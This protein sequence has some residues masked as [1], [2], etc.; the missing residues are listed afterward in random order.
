MVE[1]P[2]DHFLR[3]LMV[4]P[5]SGRRVPELMSGDM[6]WL[7]EFICDT[8]DFE[9]LPE[10]EVERRGGNGQP[11]VGVGAAARQQHTGSREPLPST[12]L[13]RLDHGGQFVVDGHHRVAAHL[14]VAVAQIDRALRVADQTVH[15]KPGAVADAQAGADE[16][17]HQQPDPRVADPIEVGWAFQLVHDELGNCP[18]CR[19]LVAARLVAGIQLRLSRQRCPTVLANSMQ[20]PSH[21]ADLGTAGLRVRDLDRQSCQVGLQR[22]PVEHIRAGRARQ[23]RC[24]PRQPHQCNAV[25]SQLPQPDPARHSPPAPPLGKVSQP[26]WLHRGEIQPGTVVA[27]NTEP[28]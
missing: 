16:D 20:K 11:P 4:D 13:L 2:S 8:G 7:T 26:D 14:V 23:S 15:L 5:P 25:P 3:H 12:R 19:C 18:R 27:G 6:D 9:P 21:T 1:Q 17:L 24:Q 28:P 10:L 22:R